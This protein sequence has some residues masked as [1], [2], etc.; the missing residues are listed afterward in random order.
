[1][2]ALER[3]MSCALICCRSFW[4]ASSRT[5][6]ER[7]HSTA[8]VACSA[9]IFAVAIAVAVV[10]F[11]RVP[12]ALLTR[13][14]I[15]YRSLRGLSVQR[16]LVNQYKKSIIMSRARCV[17]IE[18]T[19]LVIGGLSTVL[20]SARGLLG[21]LSFGMPLLAAVYFKKSLGARN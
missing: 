10:V 20:A 19:A 5:V 21:D 8:I 9:S 13:Q 14:T 4:V 15:I 3:A 11:A 2:R 6:R 17:Q 18:S 7:V 12:I 1:M 16:T